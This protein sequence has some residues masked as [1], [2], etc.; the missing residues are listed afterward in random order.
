MEPKHS[1]SILQ[2]KCCEAMLM[3]TV[4][5]VTKEDVTAVDKEAFQSRVW[6]CETLQQHFLHKSHLSVI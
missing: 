3:L 1:L 6:L 5:F 2:A 4:C